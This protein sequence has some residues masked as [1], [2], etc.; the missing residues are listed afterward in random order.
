[1]TS[2]PII[3]TTEEIEDDDWLER[4]PWYVNA[5]NLTPYFGATW[6]NHNLFIGALMNAFLLSNP[7]EAITAVGG[8]TL[9]ALNFGKDKVKLS[10]DFARYIINQVVAIND[11]WQ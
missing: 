6:S 4:W 8:Q 11:R 2:F 9:G 3:S 5:H 1:V 7:D 10:P